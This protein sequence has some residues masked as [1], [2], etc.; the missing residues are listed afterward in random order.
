M[1]KKILEEVIRNCR[2]RIK[3]G[4]FPVTAPI[5][6]ETLEEAVVQLSDEIL[7][8]NPADSKDDAEASEGWIP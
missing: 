7:A 2:L 1:H 3:E 8:S 4:D 5:H 6:R